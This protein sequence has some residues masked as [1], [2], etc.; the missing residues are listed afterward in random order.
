MMNLDDWIGS[1]NK[2]MDAVVSAGLFYILIVILVRLVG[3]RSTAQLNNFDWIIN[4]TVGSLAASG[5]LLDSVPALRAA[6][7]IA[8]MMML[9]F[10]L[11]WGVLRSGWAASVIKAKP[12]MLTHDGKYLKKAMKKT[13]VSEEEIRAVLREHGQTSVE[14]VSWIVLETDGQMTVIPRQDAPLHEVDSLSDVE[15][16]EEPNEGDDDE[17]RP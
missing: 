6:A 15:F 3:K 13:R 14:N 16:I 7:A 5:I 12:T 8:T 11:T 17:G 4:V 10:L 1:T 2:I 9:Q